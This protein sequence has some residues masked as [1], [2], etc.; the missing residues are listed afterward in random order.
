MNVDYLSKKF[1][2]ETGMKFSDYLGSQR[3][4]NAKELLV[5][6]DTEKIELAAEKVGFGNNPQYFRHIFKRYTG[7]IPSAYVKKMGKKSTDLS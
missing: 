5:S 6:C 3:V 7:M 2:R 4:E 1:I